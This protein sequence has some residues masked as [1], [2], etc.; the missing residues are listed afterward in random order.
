MQ[1][2]TTATKVFTVE[3]GTRIYKLYV[4]LVNDSTQ[5]QL[6]ILRQVQ[7]FMMRFV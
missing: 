6:I 2:E 4:E 3:Y 5:G 1:K 7:G